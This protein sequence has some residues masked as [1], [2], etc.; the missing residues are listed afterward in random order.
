MRP[1]SAAEY[2]GLADGAA[3]FELALGWHCRIWLL[4]CAGARVLFVRDDA[5]GEP[6]TWMV[7]PGGTDVPWEGRDRLDAQALPLGNFEV[8]ASDDGIL[9]KT[10][11]LTLGVRL[12]PFGLR[13]VHG[14]HAFASDRS[15]YSYEWSERTGAIRHSMVRAAGDRFY[16]LGD[17]T[18]ALDHH[19]R[20]LRT[21]ALDALGYDA[22]TSD[23]LYK[24][25]PFMIGRDA[26][27]GV[28]YGLFYDTLA[29]VTFDLGCEH[30]NYHGFYRYAEIDDGQ[31][32][33]YLFTG[34]AIRDV[35]RKFTELTG[36]MAFGPRW[37]LG[38]ANTA[39][40]LT[41]AADAQRQLAAFVE[42]VREHD[43]PLS[44][45]HFG[46][47]YSSIGKRRYVFTWNRDKFP[48]PRDA[49]AKFRELDARV[50]V[51]LK[52]CLLDDHPAYAEVAARGAFVKHRGTRAPCISQFWDGQGAHVDFTHADG[53]RWWQENL[54]SEVLDY[55]IDAGWNDNNEYE[56]WDDDGVSHGFGR[57]MPIRRSR[58]L[59]ALLMTRATAEAQAAHRPG[60][61]VYTVT[62][63][64]PPGIQRYAQTWSGD[65]TTSWHTLRWNL[66]MGLT[67][68][69]SGMFN[70]GHDIGGF[71]GPVPNAE[72]LVRWVQNGVFSPRFIM[73]SWKADG[74]TN[75][76]WLH[77]E[78]LGPI[79][80]ALRLRYRLMPYLY[81]LYRRAAQQGEPMLRPL[82]YD[83]D[84]DARAYDDCDDFMVGSQLLVAN[85]VEPAQ[86]ERRV[87]LPQGVAGWYDVATG[88]RHDAGSDVVVDAPLERIPMFAPAGAMIPLTNVEH[89]ARLHDEPS[90]RL[91]VFPPPAG[92]RAM[93]TLYE[94]D[95][96]SVRYRD[97]DFAEVRFELE[98]TPGRL[99]LAARVTGAY[100]LPYERVVVEL[101]A[102]ERRPLSLAG[103][104]VALEL[105]TAS[106]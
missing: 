93:F 8:S 28:A 99:A 82:F 1:L 83:F 49:I 43:I 20:R 65:N 30:D 18:G 27:S 80:E 26:A 71:A 95:G 16:G 9:L 63:A 60:E 39:M 6:R 41:D 13:W 100:R 72:L 3:R 88:V 25:W 90:R 51:N 75:T 81:T 68:S 14:D 77:P 79:R 15:T 52:P 86:R 74:T 58:P 40:G 46:S 84:A 36:R 11:T 56:I 19:G 67:M 61:R 42:R 35:V 64:G 87:Y 21:L 97:G 34:P 22:K 96:I 29:P 69:L 45:F 92:G 7:A 50:V 102:G 53:V 12:R 23:P 48:A 101:P 4:D 54:R 24:H 89:S 31:L 66:R 32:D 106:A 91:L 38:Y 59:H 70:V 103:D 2:I 73:N 85:V 78:A 5:P 17:K 62:R 104:G 94:D 10:S 98:A 76:P 57:E 105:A 33:Y 44:A 55:G 37:S 47:G